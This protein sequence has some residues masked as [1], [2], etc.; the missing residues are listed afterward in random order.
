[1]NRKLKKSIRWIVSAAIIVLLVMFARTI[2]WHAAWTSMRQA[3]LPLL[4][5]A[6]G[7]NIISV[8]IKGVRWW[9][10]LR[11]AGIRSLPL[12]L[13]ATIAGAGL[14]NVLVA[15][16]G[17][18]ARVVFVSRASGVSSATVLASLALEKLFDPIGFVMLLVGG[19]LLFDLP[20]QFERWRVPAE[21]L[22]VIIV[23]LLAFFVYATRNA[24]PEHVPERRTRPRTFAGRAKAYLVSFGNTAR[25]LAS[26]P[27]FAMA[28]VLSLLS[29]AAQLAT[30]ALSASAAHVTLPV[31][32]SLACLLAI[33]VGLIL[34]ATPGNVGFFQF[35]Y[36]LMAQEFGVSRNDAI[37]V[38]LLIQ[39]I[40][41][42]PLT[43]VGMALAPEFI[44]KRSKKRIAE[45]GLAAEFE[46]VE[47]KLEEGLPPVIPPADERKIERAKSKSN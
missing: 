13:R 32:G 12:S 15:Q 18:A 35:A 28:I 17:D 11:P 20:P 39:T 5:A 47:K 4:A 36:A 37:A 23:A 30:F 22:L 25:L 40:Q 9:L 21:I 2:D 29:W 27:R 7:V 44:F 33:N 42:I 10:F 34:R 1:M 16:G 8:V 41:I 6:I 45:P 38:S 26:G 3:S 43:L 24:K 46:T 14:N 31:A 19:V